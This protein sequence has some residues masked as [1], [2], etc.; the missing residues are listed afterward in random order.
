M[1]ERYLELYVDVLTIITNS[2]KHNKTYHKYFL[3][4][5]ELRVLE[6]LKQLLKPFYTVTLIL[7][8]EKY[9][10]IDM[11]L[12]SILYIRKKLEKVNID[13]ENSID[14]VLQKLLMDSFQFYMNK[15]NL[16]ENKIYI[17]AALLSPAFKNFKHATLE[18]KETFL[19]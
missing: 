18:E 3:N 14:C 7:S 9:S 4:A 16:I 1:I 10:T 15:Y 17:S 19:R 8:G 2:P 5:E 6:C 12:N 13:R 11:A